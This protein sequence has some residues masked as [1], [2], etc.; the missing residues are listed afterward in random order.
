MTS[1]SRQ[2]WSRLAA[3]ACLCLS[4]AAFGTASW[5]RSGMSAERKL[6]EA[7]EKAALDA[8]RVV[9]S[10]TARRVTFDGSMRLSPDRSA[11]E[12]THRLVIVM[13]E[14]SCGLPRGQQMVF[15]KRMASQY[16]PQSVVAV[17]V[18]RSKRFVQSWMAA[19]EVSFDVYWNTTPD[20]LARQ[21]FVTSPM[22]VVIDAGG[23]S[24]LADVARNSVTPSSQ[25][26]ESAAE[27]V[28]SGAN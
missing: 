26:F 27:R 20:L 24:V 4:I 16:G 12:P 9:M 8:A 18:A 15:A 2:A 10:Q 21:G 13:D 6:R 14:L 1:L 3:I 28:I 25:M 11:P 5:L 22:L 7:G 17:V 19:N 23:K